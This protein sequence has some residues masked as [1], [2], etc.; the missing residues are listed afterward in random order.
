MVI[1]DRDKKPILLTEIGKQLVEQ[2]QVI[3]F[4]ARKLSS[5]IK[6]GLQGEIKGVLH[7]GVIPTIAPYLLPRLLPTIEKQF[8]LLD[9]RIFELQT[10]EILKGLESDEIDAGILATPLKSAKVHE[11]PLFWE[12]FSVLCQK[13][14]PLSKSKKVRYSELKDEDIWLLEEGHCLR[15]QVLDVCSLRGKRDKN[16]RFQFESGSLETL[17][18]LVNSFGGYT[19][20]PALS[21]NT[22]GD[23]SVLLPFERPIPAREIGLIS[24]RRHYKAHL[25]KALE[26]CILESVP[27][28]LRKLQTKD[29]DVLPVS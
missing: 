8:P 20:L 19:L 17:K 15:H 26:E 5:I 25:F 6:D 1:F 18:N 16:R 11:R 2:M 21:T 9:L 4:E 29:L 27:D 24:H 14:H 3:V 13:G 23:R 10:H 7:V 12:P 28:N 22:I